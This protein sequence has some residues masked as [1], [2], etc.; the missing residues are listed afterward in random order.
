MIKIVEISLS[1]QGMFM[2]CVEA[3]ESESSIWSRECR[4]KPALPQELRS[5]VEYVVSWAVAIID[6]HSMDT[7]SV[8]NHEARRSRR[9]TGANAPPVSKLNAESKIFKRDLVKKFVG[10]SLKHESISVSTFP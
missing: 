5:S 1:L 9:W 2:K 8:E 7:G 6:I 10:P 4:R 3:V